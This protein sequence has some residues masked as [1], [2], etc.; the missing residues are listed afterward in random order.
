MAQLTDVI[1]GVLAA[2]GLDRQEAFYGLLEVP[3]Q[4]LV[5][6]GQHLGGDAGPLIPRHEAGRTGNRDQGLHPL[7][8]SQRQ[9]A[10]HQATEGPA[11]QMTTLRQD[12]GHLLCQPGQGIVASFDQGTVA[13]AGQIHQMHPIMVRQLLG[14]AV[15]DST[16]H[17][18][19]MQQ[20]QIRPLAKP[21]NRYAH[22]DSRSLFIRLVPAC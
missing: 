22:L 15:P 21:L 2:H 17:A 11:E 6:A 13:E 7:G 19:T 4:H 3:R 18:P 16:I 20:H 9:L 14:Y 12:A 1:P 5:E 8:M 10:R